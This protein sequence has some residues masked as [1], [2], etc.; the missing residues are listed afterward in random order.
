MEYFSLL[1]AWNKNAKSRLG[2]N[3]GGCILVIWILKPNE[4]KVHIVVLDLF[5]M[6][7]S[8]DQIL[9]ISDHDGFA[10]QSC[11]MALPAQ[12]ICMAVISTFGD[13]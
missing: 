12:R 10:M 9:P 13:L 2:L 8:N 1:H 11:K 7:F 3:F 6:S 4:V 5:S